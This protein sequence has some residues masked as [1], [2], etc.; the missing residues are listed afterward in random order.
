MKTLEAKTAIPTSKVPEG[1]ANGKA[2]NNA[3]STEKINGLP[4]SK[5]FDTAKTE[6]EAKKAETP[7]TVK[8]SEPVKT[9]PVKAEEVQP[10]A[11]PKT[12]IKPQKPVMNLESTLKLVEELHR[13]KIQRDKLIDTIETLGDFEV[14]Q[15]DEAD[16][17]NG[18]AYQGCTL[19]ITDDQRREFSTKNPVIIKTVA[20][21]INR[22]C[23]ERLMEIEAGIIIPA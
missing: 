6:T 8:V 21:F 1:Q 10:K 22:L 5:A 13:R 12:D 19:K 14:L 2:I 7:A 11:E 15:K 17:T 9:E 3:S 23:A 4:V 16:E 20:E 18:N